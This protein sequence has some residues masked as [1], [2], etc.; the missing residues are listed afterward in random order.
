MRGNRPQKHP[1]LLQGHRRHP[2]PRTLDEGPPLVP[3]PAPRG[4]LAGSRRH[5]HDLWRSPVART[6]DR[7]SDLPALIRYIANLDRWLRYEKLVVQAP[8][9]RGSTGQLRPNPLARRMDA[10][11]DQ[12]RSAE[13]RFGL[14]AVSRLR[15]GI[16]VLD[17]RRSLRDL[18]RTNHDSWVGIEQP[19]PR[20]YF[21]E[22]VPVTP[23]LEGITV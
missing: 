12:M 10:L 14:N 2:L 22:A 23:I 18:Q 5:W 9:V 7:G 1:A 13:D 17:A 3:P 11:E 20:E 15:L 8:L 6:W 4:L 21:R 16:E 19:D